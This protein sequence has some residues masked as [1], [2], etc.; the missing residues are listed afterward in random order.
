MAFLGYIRVTFVKQMK[1]SG[2]INAELLRTIGKQLL[3]ID[4]KAP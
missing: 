4:R 3:I 1:S 2:H